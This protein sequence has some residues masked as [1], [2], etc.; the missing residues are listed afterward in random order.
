VGIKGSKDLRK[1]QVVWEEAW[2]K[3]GTMKKG[4]RSGGIIVTGAAGNR[5]KHFGRGSADEERNTQMGSIFI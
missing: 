1:T 5:G 2:K 4:K 3:E